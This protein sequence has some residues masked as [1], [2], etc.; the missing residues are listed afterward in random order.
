MQ[1]RVWVVFLAAGFFSFGALADIYDVPKVV[2]VQKRTYL[3]NKEITAQV[4]YLPLDPF[5]RYVSV[6][7]AFTWYL[8]D[9]AGWEVIN[10]FYAASI[11]S[12]LRDQVVPGLTLPYDSLSFIA[13]SNIVFTPF[14]T[15]NLLFNSSIV[16]GE[17]SIVGGV[18]T[19]G[20][21][22]GNKLCIDVGIVQRYFTGEATSIK[23]DIRDYIFLS[24]ET[25]N[26]LSFAISFAYN[27]GAKSDNKDGLDFDE[28]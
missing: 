17:T 26:Q 5:T 18:G 20:F 13:T 7:G 16:Y 1:R 22:S 19:G 24:S 23:L 11:P 6:G 9:Y 21:S 2:A 27:F 25:R 14:Y 12:G 15:K 28:E 8:T 10:G 3:L 4:G